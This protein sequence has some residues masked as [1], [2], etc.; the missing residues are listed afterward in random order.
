MLERLLFVRS[1]LDILEGYRFF[2]LDRRIQGIHHIID[3]FVGR[4]DL[5]VHEKVPFQLDA[6][7]W[8]CQCGY[9]ADELL[10]LI[11]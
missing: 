4:L 8:A 11:R 5:T 10:A 7:M 2:L 3:G 6:L 1:I 9:F